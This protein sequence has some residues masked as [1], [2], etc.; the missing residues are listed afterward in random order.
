M[1]RTAA[2]LV[3]AVTAA[4]TL[5]MMPAVATQSTGSAA[6]TQ[7]RYQHQAFVATNRHR[8]R[9]DRAALRKQDCVQRFAVRQ[10]RRM[11]R[12][13][14]MFHQELGPILSRCDLSTVGENVAYGYPSGRSVVN[15]GWM[16]SEGHRQNILNRDFRLIGIGARQSD[17]GTWYAAQVF[18]RRAR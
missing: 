8:D 15:L 13:E 5:G 17:D 3:A 12:Q 7:G 2:A 9:H 18:G 10:A 11:A 1:M 4:M 16:R 14:R 6:S